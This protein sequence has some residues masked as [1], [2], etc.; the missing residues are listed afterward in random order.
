M[1]E[2]I[3]ADGQTGLDLVASMTKEM[4]EHQEAI[5]RLSKERKKVVVAL[6]TQFGSA[7]STERVT[8]KKIAEAMGT[9][10][11]SVYKILF[12]PTT[13]KKTDSISE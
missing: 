9:T 3:L 6:R 4:R 13:K 2:I 5:A 12:P 7:E 1:S 8:F 10:D 11:Q